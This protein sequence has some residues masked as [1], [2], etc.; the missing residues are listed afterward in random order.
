MKKFFKDVIGELRNPSEDAEKVLD[1]IRRTIR[2]SLIVSVCFTLVSAIYSSIGTIQMMNVNSMSFDEM[3]EFRG[4][5]HF[6]TPYIR[7]LLNFI[8]GLVLFF[9][10]NKSIKEN[11]NIRG[12]F[13]IIMLVIYSLITFIYRLVLKS[14]ISFTVQSLASAFVLACIIGNAFITF[15]DTNESK[16]FCEEQIRIRNISILSYLALFISIIPNI[17]TFVITLLPNMRYGFEYI[18]SEIGFM[19]FVYFCIN[20]NMQLYTFVILSILICIFIERFK[21]SETVKKI[22]NIMF[23]F[24]IIMQISFLVIGTSFSSI[25]YIA[26][27]I[28][29]TGYQNKY[30]VFDNLGK[31]VLKCTVESTKNWFNNYLSF[32]E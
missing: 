31:R 9:S 24:Y 23:V 21:Y 22:R 1:V 12:K 26:V 5:V 28:I 10:C 7:N 8:V 3:I 27:F 13:F 32:K 19:G 30:R 20:L 4:I 11:E 29:A 6:I 17:F 25:F 14:S 16:T 2:A 18:L 15:N